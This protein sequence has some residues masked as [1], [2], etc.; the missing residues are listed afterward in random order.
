MGGSAFIQ[1]ETLTDEYLKKSK[2]DLEYDILRF[3]LCDE[4]P[5]DGTAQENRKVRTCKK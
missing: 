3:L 1:I 2:E 5:S 4:E